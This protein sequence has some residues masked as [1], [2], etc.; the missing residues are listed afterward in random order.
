MTICKP[1]NCWNFR[2]I[3]YPIQK[4]IEHNMF[5]HIC[6]C[7]TVLGPINS[8]SY[9][10]RL[11]PYKHRHKPMSKCMESWYAFQMFRW[12]NH[13]Q[14][15][16]KLWCTRILNFSTLHLSIHPDRTRPSTNKTPCKP[17]VLSDK[18][19]KIYHPTL[20][21]HIVFWDSCWSSH[22]C[23]MAVELNISL[24]PCKNV[25]RTC[26]ETTTWAWTSWKAKGG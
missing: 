14:N 7:F 21:S 3:P 12:Y 15:S 24:I 18:F 19:V 23:E 6:F 10:G 5:S 4:R 1:L 22:P 9:H 20:F 11:H 17:C 13:N 8:R 25:A 2:N 26:F 16:P